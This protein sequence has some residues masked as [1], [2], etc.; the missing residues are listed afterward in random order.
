MMRTC[1]NNHALPASWD[2]L[3]GI[4][5]CSAHGD[6]RVTRYGRVKAKLLVFPTIKNMMK[7]WDKVLGSPHDLTKE[8]LGVVN[9]L[10]WRVWDSK[11]GKERQMV[12]PTYFAIIGLVGPKTDCMTITHESV[13]AAL[14]YVRRLGGKAN[15]S[16]PL[17]AKDVA[18]EEICYPAGIIA[19]QINR[20][21]Y[22]NDLYSAQ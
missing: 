19:A 4:K 1:H 13:H 5:L 6:I 16:V 8:C 14:F 17:E 9:P 7:F 15:H 18:D 11:T 12:D 20:F 22:D 3:P 2:G 21:F 10:S